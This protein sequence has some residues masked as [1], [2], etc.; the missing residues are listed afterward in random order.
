MADCITEDKGDIR[1]LRLSGELTI[2]DADRLRSTLIEELARVDRIGI[3]L[4][5]VTDVDIACLQLFCAAHKTSMD[6]DKLI[7]F[8]GVLPNLFKQAVKNAG[9]LRYTRC[10]RD[11]NGECLWM[12]ERYDG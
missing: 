10:A 1:I 11:V 12:G 6:S 9:Y 4:S 2:Q 3:D 5:S 8:E 7:K